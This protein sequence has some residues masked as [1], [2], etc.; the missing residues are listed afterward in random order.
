VKDLN[1]NVLPKQSQAVLA[2]ALLLMS[3]SLF[4]EPNKTSTLKLEGAEAILGTVLRADAKQAL[5]PRDLGEA[6]RALDTLAPDAAAAKWIESIGR[7]VPNQDSIDFDELA[8]TPFGFSSWVARLPPKS[9]WPKMQ[10]KL[11]VLSLQDNLPVGSLAKANNAYAVPWLLLSLLNADA[12]AAQKAL[13]RLQKAELSPSQKLGLAALQ[14][15]LD[16]RTDNSVQIRAFERTLDAEPTFGMRMGEGNVPDLVSLQGEKVARVTLQKALASANA[17]LEFAEQGATAEL[18]RALVL[19]EKQVIKAAPWT[20]VR[21]AQAAAVFA[22]LARRFPENG[23]VVPVDSEEGSSADYARKEAQMQAIFMLAATGK[24]EQANAQ[25]A[26]ATKSD[27]R[28]MTQYIQQFRRNGLGAQLYPMTKH[29]VESS[30][31]FSA[32]LWQEHL[33]V[34]ALA[35]ES[36][37]AIALMQDRMRQA[38]SAKNREALRQ[39]YADALLSDNQL[40]PA[41]VIL[42]DIIADTSK[43]DQALSAALKLANMGRVLARPLDQ[44]FAQKQL[45][46]LLAM[47]TDMRSQYSRTEFEREILAF[48]LNSGQIEKAEQWLVAKLATAEAPA[49]MFE[50]SKADWW[51]ELIAI[52]YRAGRFNDVLTLL[53]GA[54]DWGATDISAVL[55]KATQTDGLP[56]GLITADALAKTGQ[57][58]QAIAI[59]EQL[60]ASAPGIDPA[61]A[62]YV[63]L[64]AENALPFLEKLY[65]RDQFQERP[66]IWRS[67]ALF[68]A[69][70]L[71]EAEKAARAAIAI[72]PSDGEQKF[73]NRMRVY[74][75]LANILRAKGNAKDAAI[76]DGVIKTIRLSERADSLRELGLHRAAIE[77][78]AQSLSF[79]GDAYCVQSRLAVELAN[80]GRSEEAALHYERAFSLMPD[81]FGRMES[82]C[83]GCEGVFKSSQSQ[84]IAEKTFAKMR[85]AQPR[86]AQ[87]PYLQGYLKESMGDYAG[88]RDLYRVAVQMDGQYLNAWK[89]LLGVAPYAA[90]AP[91][92]ASLVSLELLKL[93]PLL[94]HSEDV[95]EQITDLPTLLSVLNENR[96]YLPNYQTELL[97]L[98]ASAQKIAASETDEMAQLRNRYQHIMLMSTGESQNREFLVRTPGAALA[99]TQLIKL[100]ALVLGESRES[101]ID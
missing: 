50:Q 64:Q 63:E 69:G 66:L 70:K 37:A 12:S 59:L 76:F 60:L 92:E 99:Q 16:A 39:T 30:G 38:S 42:K 1:P 57:R 82:H 34:A 83:F 44:Q 4:A 101:G 29:W 88:A 46:R 7:Y 23:A 3:L 80:Q 41:I 45:E 19:D 9:Q 8:M 52:Y 5:T 94:R 14:N 25:L 78:Y 10:E 33:A 43:P 20:L 71:A 79:F 53:Q 97:P 62:L 47:S 51:L 86:K 28:P 74:Q 89:R 2:V 75:S 26:L 24:T 87:I 85:L 6:V 35:G 91:G 27:A 73:G 15:V 68:E 61:Y 93:D 72:D 36:K 56:L 96:A 54:P 67:I 13:Q 81:S 22:A 17:A 100:M 31:T 11:G 18:A 55:S 58:P 49:N 84:T 40:E 95:L 21:G 48:Y 32:D 65:A 90:L 98:R 77:L